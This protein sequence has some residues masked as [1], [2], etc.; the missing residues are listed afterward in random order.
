MQST[1]R[2]SFLSSNTL[3]TCSIHACRHDIGF[4]GRAGTETSLWR[5]LVALHDWLR[6]RLAVSG[7]SPYFP[8][9]TG[10]TSLACIQKA[11]ETSQECV[12]TSLS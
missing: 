11:T 4:C 5:L 3:A 2:G 7:D 1:L 10:V 8:R 6:R 12:T 9:S